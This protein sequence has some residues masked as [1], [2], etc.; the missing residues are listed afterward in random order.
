VSERAGAASDPTV[1][2]LATRAF[3]KIAAALRSRKGRVLRRWENAIKKLLPHA[4]DLT[5]HQ[6]RDHLPQILDQT[7][8]AL[9]ACHSSPLNELVEMTRSHGTMRFH[10]QFNVQ[11]LIVEYRVLRRILVEEVNRGLGGKLKVGQV[12]VLNMGI[13]TALQHGVMAFI[14]HQKEQL[15]AAGEV[16]SRYL[17]YLSHDLRNNLNGCTLMLE[18]LRQ[19]LDGLQ[20]FEED[21]QDIASVQRSVAETIAGMDRILQA[22]RLRREAVRPKVVPVDLHALAHDLARQ[23]SRQAEHKGIRVAVEV[24]RGATVESDRELIT[25]VLQNLIGNAVKYSHQGTVTVA[26]AKRDDPVWDGWQISVTDQGPG[27]A[28]H[29]RDRMFEAFARGETHGQPGVGL[30]LAIAA[31]AAKLLGGRLSFETEVGVG[32]TFHFSLPGMRAGAGEAR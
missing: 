4:D 18:V 5:L 25:L 7:V 3:P 24:P 12:I 20:G 16:Q 22:E 27:I 6:L 14:N 26:A 28:Q 9:A 11:E 10:Q 32:S 15:R 2:L 31:Q 13:D 8:D 21:V 19:R 30:G 1:D 29:S 23:S 17:S